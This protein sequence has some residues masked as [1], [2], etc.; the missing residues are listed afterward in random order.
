[1]TLTSTFDLRKS[2]FLAGVAW[3]GGGVLQAA[4][5]LANDA[6]ISRRTNERGP[7]G[8]AITSTPGAV[9]GIAAGPCL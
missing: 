9:R 1:L 7:P 2:S 8:S 3:A 4:I 6:A 5:E